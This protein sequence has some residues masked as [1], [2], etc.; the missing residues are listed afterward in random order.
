MAERTGNQGSSNMG[1]STTQKSSGTSGSNTKTGS[2]GTTQKSGSLSTSGSRGSESLSSPGI[3]HSSETTS[4]GLSSGNEQSLDGVLGLLQKL[5][6]DEEHWRRYVSEAVSNKVQEV[7]FRDVMER[8]KEYASMSGDK[9]KELST[10]NPKMF[11]SGLAAFILGAGMMASAAK[12]GDR[13]GSGDTSLAGND[14][15]STV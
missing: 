1:S 9:L 2:T 13:A 10:K 3:S 14:F 8:A 11:Y 7:E 15:K 5:G 6:M 12:L 4:S